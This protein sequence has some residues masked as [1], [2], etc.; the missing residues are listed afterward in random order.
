[1]DDA[2]LARHSSADRLLREWSFRISEQH[3]RC[4]VNVGGA[5]RTKMTLAAKNERGRTRPNSLV[6]GTLIK[7]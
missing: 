3:S 2:I 4:T 7:Y 5:I 1:M 6:P